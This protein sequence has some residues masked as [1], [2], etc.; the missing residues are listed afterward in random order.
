MGKN[1]EN[2]D[3]PQAKKRAE[4]F[5]LNGDGAMLT[6]PGDN[7]KYVKFTLQVG[8]LPSID[9]HN[10]EMVQNRIEEYFTMC[11]ENDMKPAVSGLGLALGLDRRRLWEIKTGNFVYSSPA[12]RLPPAVMDSVKKAYYLME[13]L[14]ENY[15]QNGK[16]NP[17]AGIFLGKNNY[18]YLDKVEHVVTAKTDDHDY[19]A[20]DIAKRYLEDGA[21]AESP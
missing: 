19:N 7:S 9:L 13:N 18:G 16:V 15:M 11:W 20:E 21:S 8:T 17:I 5:A 4:R 10:P 14:W 3:V 2:K 6:E 1:K 12:G